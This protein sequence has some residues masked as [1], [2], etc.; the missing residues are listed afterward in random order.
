MRTSLFIML[1]AAGVAAGTAAQA[2]YPPIRANERYCLEVFTRDGRD[3]MLCR[4]E[5]MQQCIW[6][7][8]SQMDRC[9]LN[10]YLAFQQRRK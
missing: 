6:S 8:T 10:P 1:A 9:M 2:Q 3:S 4:Y 7:K 5:T